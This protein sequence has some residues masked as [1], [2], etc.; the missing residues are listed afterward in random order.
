[1]FWGG[2]GA[3]GERGGRGA[4]SDTHDASDGEFHSSG[5]DA[6]PGAQWQ[7]R[8]SDFNGAVAGVTRHGGACDSLNAVVRP[9]DISI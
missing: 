8:R 3:G 5:V 6:A 1:M 7:R 9:R 4:I 2:G